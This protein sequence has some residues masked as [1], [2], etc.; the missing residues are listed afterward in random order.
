MDKLR[1]KD[2]GTYLVQFMETI[3]VACPKCKNHA[4]V[5]STGY[6]NRDRQ[7]SR[8]VCEHCSY[9]EERSETS[10]K[11][12]VYGRI[13]QKCLNC[14]RVIEKRLNG[15]RYL[16][17][18]QLECPYCGTKMTAPITWYPSNQ[19]NAHDPFF[20]LPLWF[21]EP[22]K[23]HELWAYNREHLAFIKRV[24]TAELREQAQ[25]Q[26]SALSNRLPKWMLAKKNRTEILKAIDRLEKP[27]P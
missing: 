4:L 11:G 10:W 23:G 5:I 9:N 24:V 16:P 13:N 8:I 19:E 17:Q 21:V 1:F 20:G 6:P 3:S 26:N 7:P 15:P 22:V 18:T 27:A 2:E 12:P 25:N 14:R